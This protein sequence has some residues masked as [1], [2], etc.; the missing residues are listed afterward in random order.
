M[1][2]N[3]QILARITDCVA[4]HNRRRNGRLTW[5][6]EYGR[7]ETYATR[8][9]TLYGHDTHE[10][11]SVLAGRSR[12]RWIGDFGRGPQALQ[13]ARDTL[14][15]AKLRAASV[16]WIVDEE[17]QGGGTTYVPVEQVVAHLPDDTDY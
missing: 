13:D 12:R 6:V 15:A 9:I 3:E 5:T 2:I 8:D 7:G 4:Q 10:R 17:G 1:T 14:A 16:D 11:S